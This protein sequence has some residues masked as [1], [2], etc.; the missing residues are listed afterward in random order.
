MEKAEMS[1][2]EMQMLADEGW[3]QMQVLLLQSSIQE[4]K[5][6]EAKVISIRKWRLFSAIAAS[7][8]A[9]VCLLLPQNNTFKNGN[10]S[11]TQTPALTI[12]KEGNIFISKEEQRK[13]EV[14]VASGMFRNSPSMQPRL[15]EVT[16]QR[17]TDTEKKQSQ[18][19]SINSLSENLDVSQVIFPKLN[20]STFLIPSQSVSAKSINYTQL[21]HP[22]FI[23]ANQKLSGQ[24]AFTYGNKTTDPFIAMHIPK[25]NVERS[26]MHAPHTSSQ[27][28][29]DAIAQEKE[30]VD[31]ITGDLL[32]DFTKNKADY[33]S[34][35]RDLNVQIAG[36][37]YATASVQLTRSYNI[38]R[39]EH[40]S[41]HPVSRN[42]PFDTY[43][44]VAPMEAFPSQS[45]KVITSTTMT[46][47]VAL[48]GYDP[49]MTLQT[50]Y[51]MGRLQFKAAYSFGSGTSVVTQ[52]TI[53]L[54]RILPN[55]H[56][57]A[58]IEIRIGK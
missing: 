55:E 57:E 13:M 12:P 43:A 25:L 27:M 42:Q 29:I 41:L 44:Q 51:K 45:S 10:I 1:F 32:Q 47:Q 28:G 7:I 34:V 20:A 36:N 23:V 21:A 6:L 33:S 19:L 53:G 39:R 50:R 4:E 8:I 37:L 14:Q 11:I 15:S 52:N 49:A 3:K 54:S 17:F 35:A 26:V 56:L 24:S 22:S 30:K 40:I 2:S 18:S 16:L 48:R 38:E 5:H 46:E 9:A 31:K 58:G